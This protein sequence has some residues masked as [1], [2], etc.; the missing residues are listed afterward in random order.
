[1][2]TKFSNEQLEE[3]VE[4]L[5]KS[6]FFQRIQ[7]NYPTDIF[8]W[9]SDVLVIR[10]ELLNKTG[11]VDD[12][13]DIQVDPANFASYEKLSNYCEKRVKEVIWDFNTR[14]KRTR[15]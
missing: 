9:K 6:E 3:I 7:S 13:C 1:M 14:V 4:K 2:N 12:V 15:L 11:K 10:I 8:V 5:R